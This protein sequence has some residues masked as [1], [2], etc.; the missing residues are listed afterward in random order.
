MTMLDFAAAIRATV[1]GES[2]ARE[3]WDKEFVC[4]EEGILVIHN[5]TGTHP[6]IMSIADIEAPD[7]EVVT[8]EEEE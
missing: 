6:W 8:G 5:D 4:L 3:V 7:W 2:V 1:R